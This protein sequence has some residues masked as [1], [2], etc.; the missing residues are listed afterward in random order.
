MVVVNE[1]R[2]G[3]TLVAYTRGDSNLVSSLR[4]EASLVCDGAIGSGGN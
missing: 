3:Q 2:V 1:R 4:V